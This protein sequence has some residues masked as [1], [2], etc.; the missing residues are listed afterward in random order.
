MLQFL[1]IVARLYAA[2]EFLEEDN[3]LLESVVDSRRD[4]YY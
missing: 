1:K 2:F 3:L 4:L